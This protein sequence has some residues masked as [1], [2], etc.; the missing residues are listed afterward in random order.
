MPR[1]RVVDPDDIVVLSRQR[2][3]GLSKWKDEESLKLWES[4]QR[5]RG[6][7]ISKARAARQKRASESGSERQPGRAQ[8][9]SGAEAAEAAEGCPEGAGLSRGAE[10]AERAE[11]ARYAGVCACVCVCV[12]QCGR[13]V[14]QSG[15]TGLAEP[16]P[17][18]NLHRHSHLNRHSHTRQGTGK[19]PRRVRCEPRR[20]A[21]RGVPGL[22]PTAHVTSKAIGSGAVFLSVS[23]R[24]R[25]E[26]AG[27]SSEVMPRGSGT[28]RWEPCG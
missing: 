15:Q 27:L 10:G 22:L 11:R 4:Q 13:A 24:R 25:G 23:T 1:L 7:H 19:G 17:R 9:C 5:R 18:E 3:T 21:Q 14:L 16:C 6:G 26:G 8:L 28:R 20:G 12:Q 2:K